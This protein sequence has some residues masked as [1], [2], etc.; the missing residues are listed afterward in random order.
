MYPQ[1]SD[2][3]SVNTPDEILHV[4]SLWIQ[5]K[6]NPAMELAQ[7]HHREEHHDVDIPVEFSPWKQVF[8]K[9]SAERFPQSRPYDHAIN[10]KPGFEPKRFKPYPLSPLERGKLDEFVQE[11]LR[12]GYIR[13]SSS[14]MASPFFFVGKKDGTLRPCQDYRYLN[15]WTVKNAYP[16]P[17]INDLVDTL[18]GAKIFTKLDLRAGYNNVRIKEGDQWKGAFNTPQGLFEPTVMFFGLC[19]SPA[20]FQAMMNH[21]FADMIAEGWLVIYMDDMLLASLNKDEHHGRTKRVLQRLKENDLFLKLEKCLFDKEEVDFLGM[22]IRHNQVAMDPIK[23]KGILEW[24]I[25][26][27]VREVRS[28]L[29]FGNFYRRFIDHYSELARPLNDLTK[30]DH[31]FLWTTE[32]QLAFD[33]LKTKFTT[34]PVLLMPDV[35]KPFEVESDASK[36]AVGAVL[37]QQD[38][39]G[40]WHPC[41]YFSKSLDEAE[42]NYEIYDREL[43]GIIEALGQWRHYLEGAPTPGTHLYGPQEPGIFQKGTTTQSKTGTVVLI[44]IPI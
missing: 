42:R 34:A 23:I 35:S 21:L 11:N 22:I 14:P 15:E 29:G 32:C 7:K 10:L 4:A 18:K 39:N 3:Y 2:L 33:T 26:T 6:I 37:R 5:A 44:P 41:A 25:P 27:T 16:L 1:S 12:K 31:Q 40:D 36:F 20:T 13:E 30:K 28:F 38:C 17:L 8:D 43:L 9:K 24:K 19:N